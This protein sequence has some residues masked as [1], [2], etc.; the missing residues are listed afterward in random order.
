[1]LLAVKQR[2]HAAVLK[3]W[4]T[5]KGWTRLLIP[6]TLI[7]KLLAQYRKVRLLAKNRW[8]PPVPILVVGN[9]TVGGTGKT[10]VVASLVKGLQ[11]R[12][13]SPGIISRGFGSSA[14]GYP[15]LVTPL[16]TPEEVGD[17][18]LMLAKQLRVPV[19]VDSNR[20]QA[21]QALCNQHRCDLIIADDGLQ[22]YNLKRHVELLVIDGKR[23]LGNNLCLPAGPLREPPERLHTVDVVLINGTPAKAPDFNFTE[24]T[25]IPESLKPVATNLSETIMPPEINTTV[26]AIAGIGHPDR[27]FNTLFSLGF[28]VIA[29]AFPDH[30]PFR[31]KDIYF[32]DDLPVIMTAKDAM[33]C[34]NFASQKHWYLPVIA[35]ISPTLIDAVVRLTEHSYRVKNG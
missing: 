15:R 27:F 4:F 31:A 17:E 28:K 33:K 6:L 30:Y 2:L 10:P 18:P 24:F 7:F 12:G 13:Y 9:I 32:D 3:A 19:M 34:V 1:M 11:A 8:E 25:L 29:H 35:D 14:H 5:D 21:A 16:S 20:V 23:M 22:H 26:H